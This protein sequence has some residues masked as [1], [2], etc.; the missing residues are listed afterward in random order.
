MSAEEIQTYQIINDKNQADNVSM[1]TFNERISMSVDKLISR[2]EHA[3]QDI[4]FI[5]FQQTDFQR[6]IN[7][8]CRTLGFKE[9]D[10]NMMIPTATTD[11]DADELKKYNDGAEFNFNLT[12]EPISIINR[13]KSQRSPNKETLQS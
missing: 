1:K 8:L 13:G 5:K 2:V 4:N 9:P 6:E 11:L 12:R 3:Q 10:N 7:E